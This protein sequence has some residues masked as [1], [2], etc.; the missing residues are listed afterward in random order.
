MLVHVWV[1]FKSYIKF[2]SKFESVFDFDFIF[3]LVPVWVVAGVRVLVHVFVECSNFS[4]SHVWDHARFHLTSSSIWTKVS[5][6]QT[7]LTQASQR[8]GKN[9]FSQFSCF[10]QESLQ[11]DYEKKIY[12]IKQ[13]WKEQVPVVDVC[14]IACLVSC[15]VTR[16][17]YVPDWRMAPCNLPASYSDFSPTLRKGQQDGISAERCFAFYSFPWCL[18]PC[19][20]PIIHLVALISRNACGRG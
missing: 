4:L 20:F 6:R 12:K 10:L 1:N 14:I 11:N 15:V 17:Q 2:V 18:A 7:F 3:I 5:R 19:L 16:D 8:R 13:D 9:F